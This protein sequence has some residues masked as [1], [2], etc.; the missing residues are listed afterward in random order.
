VIGTN[1]DLAPDRTETIDGEKM[2][3]YATGQGE[4]FISAQTGRPRRVV[5]PQGTL[6]YHSWGEVEP[7][8]APD[9]NCQEVGGGYDG[10]GGGNGGG[11]GG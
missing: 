6:N 2:Y 4:V 10:G 8:Q 5:T 11:Y 1:P 7:I 3:V 9:M